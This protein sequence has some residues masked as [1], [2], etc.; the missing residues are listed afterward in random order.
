MIEAR[1]SEKSVSPATEPLPERFGRYEVRGVVGEGSMG[2]IYEGYD[3][4]GRRTVAIKALRPENFTSESMEECVK[5]FRREAQAA[6][7][8][9]HPNIVTIFDVGDDYFVMELLE[10]ETLQTL[11]QTREHLSLGEAL[12]ILT[13]V[14][15]ALDY[16][17]AKGVIHRDIKPA[18]IMILPD[19]RVKLTDFGIAHLESTAM[20]ASGMFL[21][22]PCYMAPE[23]V[24]NSEAT[25]RADLFSFGVV[26]YE[27]LTGVKPFSGETITAIV[28]QVVHA[29]A[30]APAKHAPDLPA[31]TD[32]VFARALAKEPGRRFSSAREFVNALSGRVQNESPTMR[33][34]SG[35]VISATGTSPTRL[36]RPKGGPPDPEETHDLRDSRQWEVRK[37]AGKTAAALAVI[38]LI[39]VGGFLAMRLSREPDSAALIPPPP[40]AASPPQASEGLV[41]E[42]KPPGAQVLVDGKLRGTAP[43]SLTDLPPGA[44]TIRLTLVGYAPTEVALEPSPG[45]PPLLFRL[46]PLPKAAVPS[47][48][49]SPSIQPTPQPVVVAAA[50]SPSP[51]ASPLAADEVVEA[52]PGVV[53][54]KRIVGEPA[55]Y[56]V[57][58]ERLKL[59][60]SV[61]IEIIVDEN[62]NPADVKVIH[63]AGE[64][65][66][67]A[68]LA[69]V[70][71]WRYEPATRG[72]IK[73]R[74]RQFVK[75]TF[76]RAS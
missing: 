74:F 19:G 55:S 50:P 27:T 36:V 29:D 28:F 2:R 43:L 4:L 71:K 42:T 60:G 33:T 3:P 38:G 53:P 51:H 57:E 17:H 65:L 52:G 61:G 34:A 31:W 47:P 16:A 44:H 30:A 70:A 62:G 13:P 6:G 39:S 32:G 26:A 15:E 59:Q 11:L 1:R 40:A 5:R 73:V 35:R 45:M 48:T 46:Q 68:T 49:P 18:N 72:G 63:S 22:S 12:T 9:S 64:V 8:L 20:T 69:A 25:D 66:D 10:G 7:A 75:Q 56:P 58:A 41:V 67:R 14:A 24:T 54:P 37:P 21:G 23:Q 76:R